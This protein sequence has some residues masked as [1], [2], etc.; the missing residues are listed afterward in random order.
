MDNEAFNAAVR[1]WGRASNDEIRAALAGVGAKRTGQLIR[2]MKVRT[3]MQFGR[4]NR[5]TF[6]FPRYLVF[7]E[8]GAGKGYG[9]A[10]GSQWQTAGQRRKTNPNSKGKMGTGA[11]PARPTY[12]PTM[13]RR[14]PILAAIAAE[15][16]ADQAVRNLRI[17]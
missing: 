11:R 2:E 4:V 17:K 16:Y 14:V 13:D 9:G 1:Q 8:K 15:F 7:V 6:G 10:K 5:V 3:G 12:N